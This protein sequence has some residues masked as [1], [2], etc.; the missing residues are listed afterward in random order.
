MINENVDW[1]SYI[2]KSTYS[3]HFFKSLFIV[4]ESDASER[5]SGTETITDLLQRSGIAPRAGAHPRGVI[6]FLPSVKPAQLMPALGDYPW[7]KSKRIN[8]PDKKLAI[9]RRK[10]S[11][12]ET[13]MSYSQVFTDDHNFLIKLIIS[14]YA[15]FVL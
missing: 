13:Y 8:E 9:M 12:P 5:T 15:F 14:S 1:S 3:K 2:I 10:T 6:Q 11:V 4:P 7:D